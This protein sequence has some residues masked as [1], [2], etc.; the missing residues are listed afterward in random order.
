MPAPYSRATGN[1][2]SNCSWH[3]STR[4]SQARSLPLSIVSIHLLPSR[5]L[6][7]H[8]FLSVN[9]RISHRSAAYVN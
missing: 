8:T 1:L 5:V 9:L 3:A 2:G 7:S 6:L 4:M